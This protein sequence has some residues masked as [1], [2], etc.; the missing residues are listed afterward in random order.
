VIVYALEA[1]L[2]PL[3]NRRRLGLWGDGARPHRLGAEVLG[4]AL[5]LGQDELFALAQ[6][7]RVR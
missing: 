6:T 5:F 7:G 3:L 4:Y 1:F 2:D